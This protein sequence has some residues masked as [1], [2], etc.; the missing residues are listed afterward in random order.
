MTAQDGLQVADDVH[1]SLN[2]QRVTS[3]TD[4][5]EAMNQNVG[6][7][8]GALRSAVDS[9]TDLEKSSLAAAESS[10]AVRLSIFEISQQAASAS[11]TIS[12]IVHN[13]GLAQENSGRFETAVERI[14]SVVGLIKKIAHQT[15]LLALN[16]KIEA[17]I[18]AIE[19]CTKALGALR[20][21]L[22]N[23]QK[24]A[25][26][27]FERTTAMGALLGELSF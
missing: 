11:Q 6:N 26:L 15:N 22:G 24:G 2:R 25:T 19:I 16:A 7:A 5:V 27:N 20:G 8:R 23:I 21:A 10:Q 13:V 12:Q 3:I 4:L 18:V 14:A 1:A 17:A 9:C